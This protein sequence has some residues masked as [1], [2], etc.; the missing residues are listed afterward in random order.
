MNICPLGA[1]DVDL[2][3][4]TSTTSLNMTAAKHKIAVKP[5]TRPSA[6]IQRRRMASPVSIYQLHD[7]SLSFS[8]S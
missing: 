8:L 5:K 6:L 4:V 7:Y 2:D 3:V 1:N